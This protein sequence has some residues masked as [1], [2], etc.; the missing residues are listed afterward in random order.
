M[1][2]STLMF[3]NNIKWLEAEDFDYAKTIALQENKIVMMF[4]SMEHCPVCRFMKEKVFTVKEI[5]EYLD[6]NMV[7]LYVD[8]DIDD[9]P[10]GLKC[11]GT[12]TTYFIRSDGSVID[13]PII[14]GTKAPYYIEK[15]QKYV[16]KK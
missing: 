9:I 14:G 2:F 11:I 8:L 3:A 13:K 16:D 6:K 4:I 15:L 12:P 1:I 7:M 10:M 5:E